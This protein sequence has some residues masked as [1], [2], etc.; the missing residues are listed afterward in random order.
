MKKAEGE[1]EALKENTSSDTP[2][3]SSL[4]GLWLQAAAVLVKS[5]EP[6][7]TLLGAGRSESG[8]ALF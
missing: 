7:V 3:A 6:E 2:A 1:R 8:F 5:S 4:H